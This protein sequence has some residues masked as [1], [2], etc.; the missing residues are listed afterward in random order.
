MS[1]KNRKPPVRI[2]DILKRRYVKITYLY[3]I[4]KNTI[5][6]ILNLDDKDEE[7]ITLTL[8]CIDNI[9][10]IPS[11]KKHLEINSFT[12]KYFLANAFITY[13]RTFCLLKKEN[14]VVNNLKV[15]TKKTTIS[16][17]NNLDDFRKDK[18]FALMSLK[19]EEEC[20]KIKKY[21]ENI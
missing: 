12:S 5:Q 11:F 18:R 17:E 13:T 16:V 9:F 15:K 8:E 3:F 21:L 14:D 4:V 7:L 10:Q 1:E 19:M 2:N 6:D 20:P